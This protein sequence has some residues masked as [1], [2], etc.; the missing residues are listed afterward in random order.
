MDAAK[1]E[2]LL[3]QACGEITQ[4]ALGWNERHLAERIADI[5]RFVVFNSE[6][7]IPLGRRRRISRLASDLL[8]EE[9]GAPPGFWNEL[10]TK[11]L[12]E[13]DCSV[14]AFSGVG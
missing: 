9:E 14:P 6:Q 4:Y 1:A 13:L 5:R 8:L 7:V 11:L 12:S 10:A 3:R 2:H